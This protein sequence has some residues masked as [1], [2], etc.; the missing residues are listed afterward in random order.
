MISRRD[1]MYI[2]PDLPAVKFRGFTSI[3][4]TIGYTGSIFKRPVKN[5]LNIYVHYALF[6]GLDD[7]GVTWVIENNVDGVVCVTLRDFMQDATGFAFKFVNKDLNLYNTIIRRAI[8]RTPIAYDARANNCEHFVNYCVFGKL[9]SFQ[10]KRTEGTLDTVFSGLEL[11]VS[12]YPDYLGVVD[13]STE[14]R[15]KLNLPRAKEIQDGL[16][17]MHAHHISE[18]IK[19]FK[20]RLTQHWGV[21]SIVRKNK[22]T[23]YYRDRRFVILDA[24]ASQLIIKVSDSVARTLAGNKV[25]IYPV[26]SMRGKGWII[27]NTAKA[28]R[29]FLLGLIDELPFIS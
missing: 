7:R 1:K 4:N 19:T 26:L 6:Y 17:K 13:I 28:S 2:L 15:I 27:V 5:T 20:E 29:Q 12:L 24:E 21:S 25:V 8:E 11:Y 10:T 18:T 14:L 9:E 16:D 3:G 22:T 23:F